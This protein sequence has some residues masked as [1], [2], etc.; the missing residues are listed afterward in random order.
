MAGFAIGLAQVVSAGARIGW[1]VV[2]DRFYNGRRAV[3][4]SWLCGTAAVFLGLMALVGAG[5]I[6]GFAKMASMHLPELWA[7]Y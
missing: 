7:S 1:G 5:A 2:S 6:S 3:L 4:M